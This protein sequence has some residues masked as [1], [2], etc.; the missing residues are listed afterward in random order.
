M[1]DQSPPKKRRG[2]PTKKKVVEPIVE[3]VTEKQPDLN[4]LDSIPEWDKMQGYKN[5][6]LVAWGERN[7]KAFELYVKQRTKGIIK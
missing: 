3:I 2:R 7:P 4:T 1:S 6:E 5:P